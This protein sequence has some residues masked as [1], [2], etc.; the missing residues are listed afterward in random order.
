VNAEHVGKTPDTSKPL[1]ASFKA[2]YTIKKCTKPHSTGESLMI[3]AAIH[4]A[5]TMLVNHMPK[6][7][8][9]YHLQME[10]YW[11]LQK[12]N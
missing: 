12:I 7:S 10:E 1:L 6:N 5:E 4:I 2:A 3:T 9:K 11:I 8:G